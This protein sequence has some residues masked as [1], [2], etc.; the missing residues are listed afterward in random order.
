VLQTIIAGLSHLGTLQYWGAVLAGVASAVLGII[1]GV[2][3]PLILAIAVPFVVL[4]IN[5]P[6]IGIVLLAT[7]G[8]VANTLDTIPSVL[9]GYPGVSTQVTFLEG[10]QLA[11]RGLAA[12]TLGTIYSVSAVGGLIGAVALVIVIP[13]IRPVILNFSFGEIAA[14]ALFG[15]AM[16]SMLSR[17]A[18]LKGITAGLL[19]ILL[20]T[21]GTH[22]GTATERFTFGSLSLIEGLPL[23]AVMLGVFALP[24]VL[25]LCATRQ[26]VAARETT[27]IS[28]REVFAGALEGLRHWRITIRHSIIG[29][30]F[31]MVPGLGS[32]VIDWLSYAVGVALSKDKSQFGKGSLE[33]VIFAEAA[34]NSKE[35]GQAIPTLAFGVPAGV[36]WIF[37]LAAMLSYGIAPGPQMLGRHADITI[38]LA[39]SFGIGNLLVTIIGM[40]LTGQLAK[41]TLVPY[42][43]IG[44]VIIPL[45]FL[46]AFQGS[47]GW[48]GIIVLLAFTPIGLAMKAFKWP[49][50][51]LILGFI[52]G[53]IIEQNLQSALSAYGA[54]A[55][56]TRPITLVLLSVTVVTVF[57]LL[58]FDGARPTPAIAGSVGGSPGLIKR[59]R[60]LNYGGPWKLEHGFTLALLVIV[61]AASWM[62]LGFPPRARFLPLLTGVPIIAL[63]LFQLVFMRRTASGEIMDIGL[64]SIAMP[65][66]GRT[67]VIIA[68]FLAMQLLVA[69]TFGLAYAVIAFAVAFPIA[70]SEGRMR[71]V[72]SATAGVLVAIIALGLLD[73]YM[74]VLWP[75]A[76][77]WDWISRGFRT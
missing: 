41:L 67:A 16:V 22:Q 2:G 6:L 13:I 23:I 75:D 50:P 19:G 9:M 60:T 30:F 64:R 56:F 35:G 8:G 48:T 26:S 57:V 24:E 18:M 70:M 10:H 49:R 25:D 54:I 59:G 40:L 15:V 27:V 7:I 38:M 20:S 63:T 14:L 11:R 62:S 43:V 21:V 52:L 65:G 39:V 12:R 4:T 36:A 72:A 71:W 44:S 53:S 68:G 1:P 45:S 29:V 51:P 61:G 73:Y 33:G 46:S 28:N 5:D 31:G 34:Q 47:D 17:G 77:L 55:L 42:V 66:S 37:V 58:R 76:V 74:S 69:A 32:A 3:L